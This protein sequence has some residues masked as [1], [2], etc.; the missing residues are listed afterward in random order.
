MATFNA[1]LDLCVWFECLLNWLV[2]GHVRFIQVHNSGFTSISQASCL[3]DEQG[4]FAILL[5][6]LDDSNCLFVC[7][8]LLVLQ[9]GLPRDI[10]S[11][12]LSCMALTVTSHTWV[13]VR[14]QSGK[15]LCM[16]LTI[17]E[18]ELLLG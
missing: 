8:V 17:C 1:S 13:L 15:W 14:D 16:L 11:H 18:M 4:K 10:Q 6:W 12:I 3:L 5:C 2:L 7:S 9:T